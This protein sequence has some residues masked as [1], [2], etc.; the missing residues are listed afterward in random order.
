MFYRT[1]DILGIPISNVS[2]DETILEIE[3]FVVNNSYNAIFPTNVDMIVKS[4]ND[5]SFKKELKNAQLLIPDGMPLVWAS[6]LFRKPLKEK[7]SGS[8]IFLRICE[9]SAKK[10]HR[11]FFLGA[12]EG[13]ATKAAEIISAR[14]KGLNIVG[15]YSPPIGF[16]NDI[17]ESKKIIDLIKESKPDIL[18]VAFG[19]PKQEK[20]ICNY[21]DE[22][23]VSVSIAVG[24]TFDYVAGLKKMPPQFLKKLGFAWLWRLCDEPKR[25]WRRYLIDDMKFFYYI[26]LQKFSKRFYQ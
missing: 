26:L 18:F 23:K 9:L 10:G 21:K 5:N 4:I 17:L 6:K 22:Y 7:V 12:A 16:E 8:S 19:A 3:K 1:V 24:A 25:L 13:V 14:Y 2:Q 11:L 15:T 20:W